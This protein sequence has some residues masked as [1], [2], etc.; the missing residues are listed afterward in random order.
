MLRR[1][2]STRCLCPAPCPQAL[3]AACA[4]RESSPHLRQGAH[5]RPAPPGCVPR[6][7]VCCGSQRLVSAPTGLSV[8]PRGSP[9][10]QTP[11]ARTEHALGSCFPATWQM[12]LPSHQG[13]RR[14]VGAVKGGGSWDFSGC[15]AQPPRLDKWPHCDLERELTGSLP[16]P[17]LF[18]P[19][20]CP[21]GAEALVLK[22]TCVRGPA[23]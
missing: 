12:S 19:L 15:A 11:C 16:P 18:Q 6:G 20:T 22:G 17:P 5:P 2:P 9:S 7:P 21:Q 10:S 23:W 4:P 13:R 3:W 14:G 1:C 8:G